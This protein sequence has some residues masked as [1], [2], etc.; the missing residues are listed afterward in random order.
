MPRALWLADAIRNAGLTL[1]EEPGWQTRG[2]DYLTP[3][4]IVC[5]HTA[6]AAGSD[7]PSVRTV[8][9]GRSDVPGPLSNVVLSRS[10]VCILIASGVSNNAGVGSWHGVSG[11]SNTLGI[12]AENNGV[13]ELWP[14]K[15]YDA[16]VRLVAAMCRGASIPVGMV[17]G[18][19][20]WTPRKIDPTFDMQQFRDLVAL[21]LQGPR[22]EFTVEQYEEI[23]RRLSALRSQVERVENRVES[24]HVGNW[25]G[26]DLAWFDKRTSKRLDKL[27]KDV[28]AIK[29]KL[30]L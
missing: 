24:M 22:E 9:D 10:G 4:V 15:Q 16:Y 14:Q 25:K 17:C 7:A 19:K 20:E 12:E 2:K 18:H 3:R 27:R 8:R 23:I 30:G 28:T 29:E 5:H 6:S 11:N 26:G 1:V 21:R 13:G